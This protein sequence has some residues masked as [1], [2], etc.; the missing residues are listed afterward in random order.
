M[1]DTD[2]A[3]SSRAAAPPLS[4]AL[5]I[6]LAV[7]PLPP[8]L[9][10]PALTAALAVLR[11]RYPQVFERLAIVGAP[12]FL[13]DPVDLPFVFL[14][15]AAPD[16]PR[17]SAVRRTPNL[18]V[19][20]T[21]RG[22]L[23]ALIGL[24]QGEIDGDALFFSRALAIEGDTEAVV[25]LRNAVD[26]VEIDMREDVLRALG[27]LRRPAG[28]LLDAVAD[29]ATAAAGDIEAL[30]RAIVAPEVRRLD[31]QEARL[32][33]LGERLDEIAGQPRAARRRSA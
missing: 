30:R 15:D 22:P 16:R 2:H 17:L 13:I 28:H 23:A 29:L 14:F 8:A 20:A 10:Q 4:P 12:R 18:V 19:T 7:R 27:P 32:A 25:A 6:G 21:I 11:R 9:L 24:L 3:R 33:R 1:Q 5:V 31:T 26:G